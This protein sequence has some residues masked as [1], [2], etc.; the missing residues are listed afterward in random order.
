MQFPRA[1]LLTFFAASLAVA[2]AEESSVWHDEKG[3]P[4]PNTGFRT[5]KEGFG[6]WLF[7]TPDTDW[8]EKWD[9]SPESVPR[10]NIASVVH[11]GGKLFILT[12]FSN[13]KVD[14]KNEVNITCDVDLV[15]PDGTSSIHQRN[16]VCLR[17]KIQGSPYNIR[18]SAPVLEFLGEPKDPRGKWLVRVTLKDNNRQVALPLKTSFKLE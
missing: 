5:T 11:E 2:R 18:L 12:F 13:P 15:R 3:N 9:T 14:K 16:V 4:A 17:G 6:G 1:I 8:K 10:F 7:V